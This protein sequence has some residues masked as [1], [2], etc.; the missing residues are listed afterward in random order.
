MT[1]QDYFV[2]EADIDL[3]KYW[4]VLQRRW[5][6]ALTVSGLTMALATV[7]AN[8]KKDLYEAQA[9]LL[10]ESSSQASSLVGLEGGDKEL[11]S[12][13]SR[14]TPLDTQVEVFRSVPIAEQVIKELSLKDS[15]GGLLEPEDLLDNLKVAGVPGT[16]VLAIT[17][18]SSEPEITA[19]VVNTSMNIYIQNDIQVNR[20]AAV[21]AQ[22]FIEA[23]LPKSET[24]VAVA[25]SALRQFKE[26]NSVVDLGEESRNT[27]TV[28]SNLD[29]SL[30][31]LKSK[32]ADTTAQAADIQKNL[33]LNP[34]EAYAVGLVSESPGVQEVLVQLQTV[35]SQLAVAK[36]QYEETH[37]EIANIRSQENALVALLEKRIQIALGDDQQ[38]LPVDDLQTGELEKGLISDFLRLEAERAGLEQQ[39]GELS[40]AQT[41]QQA[42]AQ[43][44]PGLEKQQRE[45]ERKLN[46]A[47]STYETLLKNLQQAQVIENQNVGN[48]RI[49]SSARVPNQ[50]VSPP[51]KLYLLAG[52]VIGLLLGTL[53]A[54][55]ADL[56]D[57]SVKTVREGQE[58]YEYS[59]LGVIPAWSNLNA[60]SPQDREKPVIVV[61]EFHSVPVIESYQSLQA[62]LKFS[63][64]DQ[65][66]KTVAITSAV[67]GEG[68]SEVAANLALTLA[69]LGSLVLVI[70]ANMRSPDQHHIWDISELQGLSNFVAGQMDLKDAIVKREPNLHVLPAGVI[71]P[72]PLAVLESKKMATLIKAC[73]KVYDYII[74][75]TPALLGLADT[76]T[77]GKMTDGVLIV[78]QPGLAD[79][80]SIRTAKAMLAQSQQRV[81]GIVANGIDANSKPDRYFYHNQEYIS[82]QSKKNLFLPSRETA[83]AANNGKV[84]REVNGKV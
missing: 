65:P 63:S 25:E 11:K 10:F 73:E 44:L 84:S 21:A 1:S 52:G 48:A 8:A 33:Q 27:V 4:S 31:E 82:S 61:R 57:R 59:L 64:L 76:L 13:T 32:L 68:K 49:V 20:A 71:P 80:E 36:T 55:L 42:R 51:A 3:K 60:S 9:K 12:L 53:A 18:Q 72:N 7:A 47:Q 56:F 5:L 77:L 19:A 67:A 75:D 74:I 40:G 83:H 2:K 38:A 62:N 34:Q 81:L 43:T 46:A 17:Y 41:T 14:D 15:E 39:V 16:D 24:E 35:Q 29:N 69:H 37:P 66:L 22:D 6:T 79:S 78:M 45:L 54:F 58:L 23:Q 70:D 30:T 50:P 28:L 26:A